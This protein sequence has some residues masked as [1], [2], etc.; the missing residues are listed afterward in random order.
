MADL[1]NKDD[2]LQNPSPLSEANQQALANI[3]QQ[4]QPDE[5]AALSQG[6]PPSA[7]SGPAAPAPAEDKGFSLSGRINDLMTPKSD[8]LEEAYRKKTILDMLAGVQEGM[9]GIGAAIARTTPTGNADNIRQ[10]G[11][12]PIEKL[13]AQ[14]AMQQDKLKKAALQAKV[15]QGDPSSK[16]SELKRMQIQSINPDFVKQVGADNFKGMSY[17]ALDDAYKQYISGS[18][19][20]LNKLKQQ[21]LG[22]TRTQRQQNVENQQ[23]KGFAD[24]IEKADSEFIKGSKDVDAV[25]ATAAQALKGNEAATNDLKIYLAKAITGSSRI[26]QQE[27]KNALSASAGG[28]AAAAW[29]ALVNGKITEKNYSDVL[30]MVNAAEQI[31][32]QKHNEY[33]QS[34]AEHYSKRSGKD[35][36]ELMSDYKIAPKE[37]PK[38][39]EADKVVVMDSSGKKYKLP[40]S[41]LQ[42]AIKQGYKQVQ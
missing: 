18:G 36:K 31:R 29:D 15:D 32:E 6:A 13:K 27:I 34:L 40:A 17:S 41:Q 25:R 26:N 19:L 16:L 23:E 14:S 39:Q 7:P 5:L 30:D 12:L 8:P 20:E 2:E 28:K 24:K 1:D 37:A 4:E 42:D 35:I 11:N 33:K 10:M 22:E 38:Q 21:E 9:S 3:K